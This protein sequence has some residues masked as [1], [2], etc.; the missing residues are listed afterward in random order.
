MFHFTR[1]MEDYSPIVVLNDLILMS[2]Y[3]IVNYGNNFH[4]QNCQTLIC[5]FTFAC[6]ENIKRMLRFPLQKNVLLL[7]YSTTPRKKMMAPSLSTRSLKY[8]MTVNVF[9]NKQI[10]RLPKILKKIVFVQF[11]YPCYKLPNTA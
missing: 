2:L 11:S 6:Y 3:F 10:I 4:S 1:N 9:I 5:D 8:V 7:F